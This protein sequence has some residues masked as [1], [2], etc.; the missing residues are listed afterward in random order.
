MSHTEYTIVFSVFNWVLEVKV[1]RSI[2][3]NSQMGKLTVASSFTP[4]LTVTM[5]SLGCFVALS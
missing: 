3:D 1:S 4:T 5:V 2:Y